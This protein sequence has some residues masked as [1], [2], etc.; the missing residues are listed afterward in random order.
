VQQPERAVEDVHENGAGELAILGRAGEPTLDRLDV[1]VCELVPDE[2]TAALG[3]IAQTHAGAPFVRGPDTAV[4][5]AVANHRWTQW[6]E[7]RVRLGDRRVEPREDPVVRGRQMRAVDCAQRTDRIGS[8]VGQQEPTDVP[9]LRREVAAG[10]EGFFELVVV[11]DH[12]GAEP[13]S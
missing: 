12:V 10:R 4:R 5:R 2:P 13:H 6:A 3:Q 7:R 11:E 1:P 8:D 9:E